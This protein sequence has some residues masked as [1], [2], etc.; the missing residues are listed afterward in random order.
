MVIMVELNL[1]MWKKNPRT[2]QDSIWLDLWFEFS[3]TDIAI[4]VVLCYSWYV[5]RT[6]T[7]IILLYT[8]TDISE[9]IKTIIPLSLY[10]PPLMADLEMLG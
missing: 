6:Y 1:E 2:D 7:T 4:F 10:T 8:D 3:S 5:N 9:E